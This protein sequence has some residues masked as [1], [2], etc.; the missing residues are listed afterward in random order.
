V[1]AFVLLGDVRDFNLWLRWIPVWAG[2]V[3]A[4]M[5]SSFASKSGAPR[6][7]A[8]ALWSL[9][10]GFALSIVKFDVIETGTLLYFLV[11]GGLLTPC[12]LILFL[13]FLRKYPK[14][15]GEV[16]DANGN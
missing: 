3:L 9:I 4:G 15:V 5:F 16:S 1:V 10:S 11:M 2:V 13:R 12:G 14:P 6:F 7:Y 8:Y